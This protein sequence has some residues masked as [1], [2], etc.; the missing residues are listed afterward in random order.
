MYGELGS[1][2]GIVDLPPQ[3]A[4]DEAEVFLASLGYTILQRT[5]TTLTVERRTPDHPTGQ[6]APNLTVAVVPQ[7]QGGVQVRIRGNDREGMQAR[8]SEWME[9]SEGLPKKPEGESDAPSAGQGGVETPE[10]DLPPPPTVESPNLPT[11]APAASVPVPPPQPPPSTTVPPPPRQEST[12]WRGT[13]LAFGGCIVLPVLLVIGFVGCLA[14][15]GGSGGGGG[16]GG[17]PAGGE[18]GYEEARARAKSLGQPVEAG[19]L[20][21]TVTN[22]AQESELR[23]FGQRKTG[24]FV[25]V[26]LTVINNGTEAIS[27]DSESLALLDEQGRTHQTDPDASLYVPTRLDLFFQQVNP[28]VTQQARV[29]FSI[30]P[31]AGGLILRAGDAVPFTDEN[32]YVNLGI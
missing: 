18:V 24:N 11:P 28:G 2:K 9:W 31:D 15:F 12:V 19:D 7:P 22:V 27:V 17:E 30:A 26:D 6:A 10:V 8:Q 4:L 21:W 20:T 25:I 5:A 3:Q 1:V 23:S 29:I 16:G 13:K 32:A 14:L